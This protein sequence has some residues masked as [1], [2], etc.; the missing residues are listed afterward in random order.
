MPGFYKHMLIGNVEAFPQ[1]R[2]ESKGVV[3][4]LLHSGNCGNSGVAK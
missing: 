3:E 1:L 4:F 2:T